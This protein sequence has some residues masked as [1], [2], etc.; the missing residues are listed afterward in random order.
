MT[1]ADAADAAETL[2]VHCRRQACRDVLAT[3]L[4]P[5]R[6]RLPGGQVVTFRRGILLH[7]PRCGERSRWYATRRNSS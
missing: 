7:C 6:V 4:P 5:N 3:F 2:T 1:V